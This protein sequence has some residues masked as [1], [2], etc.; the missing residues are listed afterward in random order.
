M[1]TTYAASQLYFV[2]NIILTDKL[3]K[4]LTVKF[5]N[6]FNYSLIFSTLSSDYLLFTELLD[7]NLFDYLKEATEFEI[8]SSDNPSSSDLT[9]TV[10]LS[11]Y[12]SKEISQY[13]FL[14]F[15]LS[16]MIIIQMITFYINKNIY[17]S[18]TIYNLKEVSL[19][20]MYSYFKEHNHIAYYEDFSFD[21]Y[22]YFP[23]TNSDMFNTT[24]KVLTKF[25]TFNDFANHMETYEHK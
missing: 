10:V 21:R 22:F 16:F 15:I 18:T 24:Q 25:E 7:L 2:Q 19:E 8:K 20:D 9:E 23:L 4:F 13:K 5:K 3:R 14:Y 6:K 17:S 11:S 1:S 12:L